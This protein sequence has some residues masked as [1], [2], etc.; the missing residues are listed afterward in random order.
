MTLAITLVTPR[1]VWASADHR[2]TEIPSGNLVTDQ[3][4]KYVSVQCSDGAALI[5]YTGLG[6]VG[7]TDV[8]KWMREILRGE[9]RTVDET[10][11]DL[12]EQAT[13]RLGIPAMSYGVQHTFLAGAFLGGRAWAVEIKN[14]R[15]VTPLSTSALQ[16][17]FE[18]AAVAVDDK[19][20]LLVAGAG[21]L[22]ISDADWALL[23]RIADR[24]PRD[25]KEFLKLLGDVNRRAAQSKHRAAKL[26][27][28][29]CMTTYMP[30]SGDTQE[31]VAYGPDEDLNDLP[32]TPSMILFGIDLG[33]AFAGEAEAFR[34]RRLGRADQVF[35]QEQ[36]EKRL[37]K[38]GEA[39]V[40]P[41]GRRPAH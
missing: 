10:L 11:I 4:V 40:R 9:S 5:T 41:K 20:I 35:D 31:S 39:S 37:R 30:P 7:R 23:R 15:S 32:L 22:A 16:P 26:V 34:A 3:S 19:S 25:P 36:N 29:T 38:A 8:S 2:L 1:G 28:Q 12:R 14:F 17:Q 6:R 33:E 18:T 24:Q 21:R 27:S 13:A